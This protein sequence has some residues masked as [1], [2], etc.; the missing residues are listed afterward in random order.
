MISCIKNINQLHKE[1]ACF[2][3][4]KAFALS[5]LKENSPP[6]GFVILS[7][8]L[9]AFLS[10]NHIKNS[11]NKILLS[12]SSEIQK[13]AEIFQLIDTGIFPEDLENTIFNYFN[14]LKTKFVSVRSSALVEDSA[15]Y[16]W[17][18]QLETF[19]NVDK[20]RL[21]EKIK[22]CWA[23]LYSRKAISYASSHKILLS[24]TSM[25]VIIQEMIPSVLSGIAFSINPI[26]QNPNEILINAGYGLGEAIVSGE[27]TVDEYL[28]H[29]VAN[30]I[31]KKKIVVQETGLFNSETEGSF[32]KKI[33][34]N[35]AGVQKLSDSQL[36]RLS[37]IITDVE[38]K[39]KVPID[40]EFA[41][42]K[43]KF[44]ILQ[45][46][47]I[48]TTKQGRKEEQI[49]KSFER[50]ALPLFSQECFEGLMCSN[51]VLH[52]YFKYKYA[53]TTEIAAYVDDW[54]CFSPTFTEQCR[55]LYY[56]AMADKD[57]N[58]FL[59]IGDMCR[60]HL[61]ELAEKL[62]S[63]CSQNIT[64]KQL[65][66]LFSHT[67]SRIKDDMVL[68]DMLMELSDLVEKDLLDLL[69][70]K[71]IK[72]VSEYVSILSAPRYLTAF[73]KEAKSM[74]KL[75]LIAKEDKNW[76]H[77]PVFEEML[78]QHLNKYA[79]IPVRAMHGQ[80]M[81]SEDVYKRIREKLKSHEDFFNKDLQQIEQQTLTIFQKHHFNKFEKHFIDFVK[82][83]N[84]LRTHILDMYH[85]L[86][87]RYRKIF[88]VIGKPYGLSGYDF[89]NLMPQEILD[90]YAHK[91]KFPNR[92]DKEWI[93]YR[94]DDKSYVVDNPT[95]IDQIKRK[96]IQ[97]TINLV[98]NKNAVSG[99]VVFHGIVRGP[100]RIVKNINEINKIKNGD[101][102]ISPMTAPS[103]VLALEKAA[104][105]VTDEGGALCHAAILAR[106][107]KKPCITGTK[108]ATLIFKDD[109][110]IELN[111]NTATVYKINKP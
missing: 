71:K 100:A 48:T 82:E 45:V 12:S 21:L 107:M 54:L 9:E 44:Y 62:N 4:A 69:A 76:I 47:P 37:K 32:W 66:D 85:W 75:Y 106:E 38:K 52:K 81:T 14:K 78:Q 49:P 95:E 73:E 1:D 92:K 40:V 103:A 24:D 96:I 67:Q 8:A 86:G 19:L 111:T 65:R 53:E 58:A 55:D 104:G 102:V 3:G 87:F 33:D 2:A 35:K 43:N 28:L 74:Q 77:N 13:S 17:A 26:S 109:D 57:L 56:Q 94:I 105:F 89:R 99:T 46:R 50:H 70:R 110:L 11:I 83:A 84:F 20:K 41:F 10:F 6:K 97:N 91:I 42:Y 98:V 101:I 31:L 7:L 68:V 63:V 30:N 15:L 29:K 64:V 39:W 108:R 27:I 23:S 90:W 36:Y 59:K 5:H 72:N 25:A 80:Y 93:W 51:K 34:Q 18:G 88:D 61:L 79:G 60:R 16:T 22:M